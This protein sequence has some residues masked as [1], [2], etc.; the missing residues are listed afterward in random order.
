[1]SVSQCVDAWF[2]T[3]Q[4]FSRQDHK[5][6]RRGTL[7]S[8]QLIK[9]CPRSYLLIALYIYLIFCIL[10]PHSED[11]WR[12]VQISAA[13]VGNYLMSSNHLSATLSCI[14]CTAAVCEATVFIHFKNVKPQPKHFEEHQQTTYLTWAM[15]RCACNAPVYNHIYAYC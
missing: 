13:S 6:G 1:M 2:V 9:Q 8:S 11:I 5:R 10:D 12:I 4:H 14:R 15:K 3:G 7:P